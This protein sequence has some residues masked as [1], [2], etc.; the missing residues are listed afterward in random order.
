MERYEK[1]STWSGKE[2]TKSVKG[3]T[4]QPLVE[5]VSKYSKK[6]GGA[7]SSN[8]PKNL[9]ELLP[10]TKS[11]AHFTGSLPWATSV[12]SCLLSSEELCSHSLSQPRIISCRWHTMTSAWCWFADAQIAKVMQSCLGP[13]WKFASGQSLCRISSLGEW[14]VKPWKQIYNGDFRKV[15]PLAMPVFHRHKPQNR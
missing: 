3:T 4:Q 15:E 11:R 12:F 2:Q 1:F 10:G 9:E 5:K 8:R 14:P 13:R 6:L 7:L